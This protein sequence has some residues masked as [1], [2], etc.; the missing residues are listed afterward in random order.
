M[1]DQSVSGQSVAQQRKRR[2]SLFAIMEEGSADVEMKLAF[3]GDFRERMSELEQEG[4]D[5]GRGRHRFKVGTYELS[6]MALDKSV[7]KC[8]PRGVWCSLRMSVAMSGTVDRGALALKADHG[9]GRRHR[10]PY[11]AHALSCGSAAQAILSPLS[12]PPHPCCC[13]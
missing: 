5:E 6:Y 8:G 2:I 4:D 3:A 10:A 13:P 9:F 12:L 11:L 1:G 7:Q